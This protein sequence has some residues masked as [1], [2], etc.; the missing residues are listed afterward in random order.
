[1]KAS[2][3]FTAGLQPQQP[4]AGLLATATVLL[5]VMP[6]FREPCWLS[7]AARLATRIGQP[8]QVALAGDL[9]GGLLLDESSDDPVT[10]S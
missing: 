9:D 4:T 8:R 10:A 1:M 6:S 3:L 5:S 2:Q 7:V